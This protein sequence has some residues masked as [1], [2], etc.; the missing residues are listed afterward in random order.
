MITYLFNLK[1]VLSTFFNAFSASPFVMSRGS[2]RGAASAI[3]STTALGSG[4]VGAVVAGT[5][6]LSSVELVSVAGTPGLVTSSEDMVN[7]CNRMYKE[8]QEVSVKD[9]K[10]T[11]L[12]GIFLRMALPGVCFGGMLGARDGSRG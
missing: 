2:A 3:L 12:W 11:R 8:G 7:V 6:E 9:G 1:I 5:E 4:T 10:V